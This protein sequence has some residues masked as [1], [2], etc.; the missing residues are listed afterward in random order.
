MS[1]NTWSSRIDVLLRSF[2]YAK[3]LHVYDFFRAYRGDI[4]HERQDVIRGRGT[5]NHQR[6]KR[7]D[8][9]LTRQGIGCQLQVLRRQQHCLST[10]ESEQGTV[11]QP[12]HQ[13]ECGG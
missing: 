7:T 6:W 5:R 4:V 2:S 1:A 3:P 11:T 13:G 8:Y 10:S 9:M 12:T